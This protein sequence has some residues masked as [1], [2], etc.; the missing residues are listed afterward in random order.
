MNQNTRRKIHRNS[1]FCSVLTE[2]VYA[3]FAKVSG[4]SN[5]MTQLFCVSCTLSI[6]VP[7]KRTAMTEIL[8]TMSISVCAIA[9]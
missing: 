9:P 5:L 7:F 1:D 2:H 3:V 6:A 4:P 8:E